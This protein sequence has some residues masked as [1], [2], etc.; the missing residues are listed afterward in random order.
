MTVLYSNK[1]ADE[2][3]WTHAVPDDPHSVSQIPSNDAQSTPK[4]TPKNFLLKVFSKFG[5]YVL[6]Y[7]S[8]PATLPSSS[9][10]LPVPSSSPPNQLFSSS[11]PI[12]PPSLPFGSSTLPSPPAPLFSA[13]VDLPYGTLSSS[14]LR[15]YPP[16]PLPSSSPPLQLPP[17]QITYPTASQAPLSSPLAPI[18]LLSPHVP[19]L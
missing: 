17:I 9:S 18:Q 12:Q 11:P 7:C 14:P 3:P 15:P 1:M 4:N 6:S 8:P 5:N 19:F 2:Y 10:T 16:A 13:T